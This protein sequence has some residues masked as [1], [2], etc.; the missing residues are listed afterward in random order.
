MQRQTLKRFLGYSLVVASFALLAT[1]AKP[2]ER[3]APPNNEL[4]IVKGDCP[5]PIALTLTAANPTNFVAADFAPAQ[6]NA[7]HMTGLGDTSINKNF[8]YTFQWKRE[9]R[10]CQ[11]T[12]AILTVKMRSNQSGQ[13]GNSDASNDGIAMM[14]LG[15]VVAPYNEAIYSNVTKPF[16]LG[17]PAS[18]TWTLNAAALNNINT[19]GNLSFAVQDD[20]RV[21]SA[22]LQLW[23]C[24]L[25]T[26]RP[27]ASE[28]SSIKSSPK[29][30]N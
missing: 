13:S 2:Q 12:K 26:P 15:N 22:T 1:S 25:S 5:H 16:V 11:I 18:K 6:V 30:S 24:C 10:C 20:T 28:Q 14:H 27:E 21:E 3:K 19:S 4:P 23:G 17:T 7:Q 29:V 8:L 9:Q